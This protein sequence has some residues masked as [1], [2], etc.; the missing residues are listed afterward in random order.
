MFA[1]AYVKKS[2][3]LWKLVCALALAV[4]GLLMMLHG[5][6]RLGPPS[7]SDN[8]WL[9]LIVAGTGINVGSG[10]WVVWAI[11]C[12]RCGVKLLW[13]AVSEQ[14]V[15]SWLPWLMAQ[16]QCPFCEPSTARDSRMPA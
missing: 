14:A 9:L 11:K 15:N 16:E 5:V 7:N 4:A 13:P 8:S 3:Q 2:G 1:R 6:S 12:P 10:L